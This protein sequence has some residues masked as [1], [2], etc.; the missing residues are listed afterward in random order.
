[1]RFVKV[2]T[3]KIFF[4]FFAVTKNE[5][6]EYSCSEDENEIAPDEPIEAKEEIT[7]SEGSEKIPKKKKISPPKQGSILSFFSK[8]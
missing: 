4:F 8:K 6:V 1:M 3:T 2:F 5:I 7:A